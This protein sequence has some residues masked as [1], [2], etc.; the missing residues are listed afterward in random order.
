MPQLV[1][2]VI[3]DPSKVD[4]VVHA[5]I[6]SGLTGMT[7]LD[8]CGWAERSGRTPS[9]DDLPLFPSLRKVVQGEEEINRLVFSVVADDFDLEK[10]IS[11]TERV[12]GPLSEP[13]SGILFVV[14][15]GR[16]F[17]LRPDQRSGTRT[18]P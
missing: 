14:P 7:L 18:A 13:H 17:G 6:E 4:D 16:V 5:W 15:V 2:L 8:S 11:A 9:R 10:L 12:L 1:V 3:D